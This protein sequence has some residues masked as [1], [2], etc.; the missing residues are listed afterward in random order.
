MP[1][2]KRRRTARLPSFRDECVE[3]I[4]QEWDDNKEL[5]GSWLTKA[6]ERDEWLA[7]RCFLMVYSRQTEE[8]QCIGKT[9]VHNRVGFSTFDAVKAERVLPAVRKENISLTRDELDIVRDLVTA[10]RIQ[11]L[12]MLCDSSDAEQKNPRLNKAAV[13]RLIRF[14][15]VSASS[16]MSEDV[17]ITETFRRDIE[18]AP[19]PG[20]SSPARATTKSFAVDYRVFSNAVNVALRGAMA[21]ARPYTAECVIELARS[22]NPDLFRDLADYD[23]HFRL[24][25]YKTCGTVI[26][27]RAQ[28]NDTVYVLWDDEKKWHAARVISWM[29]NGERKAKVRYMV[30][31]LEGNITNDELYWV[32]SM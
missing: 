8:E 9:F 1:I 19:P 25:D 10:Y 28:K 21:I 26:E 5:A 30:D 32:Y 12:E 16:D 27:R 11:V 7:R 4:V 24:F 14:P 20:H 15:E 6:A 13:R 18:S 3:G 22:M 23:L 2:L 17:S 29:P 31:G